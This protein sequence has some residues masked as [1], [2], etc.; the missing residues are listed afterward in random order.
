MLTAHG[1]THPG[2]V[3]KMNE[4]AFFCDPA[5][6]LFAVADGMGGHNAGEI[7]S[8]LGI[9]TLKNFVGRTQQSDKLTWPFGFD[10]RLSVPGNSVLTSMRLANRRV[11]K[12]AETQDQYTGMG[13]TL[14]AALVSGDGLAYASVGDTRLYSLRDGRLEPLTVDD[15]WVATLLA[16]NPSMDPAVLATHPMRNVLTKVIGLVDDLEVS[17]HER[18]LTDGETLLLCSDGL[19]ALVDAESIQQ[20]LAGHETAVAVDR[21]IECAL[22]R[23]GPDNITVVLV[24]YSASKA[25]SAGAQS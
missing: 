19:H 16:E 7:A 2:R 15:S 20:I 25:D 10:S 1:A 4:D 8:A 9:E 18:V 3:R 24:R 14:T 21:L 22:E 13:T 23:G 6:G 12:A 11:F 5:L 17:A